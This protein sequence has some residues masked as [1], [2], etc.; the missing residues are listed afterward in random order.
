MNKEKIIEKIKK[1]HALSKS[2]LIDLE[3]I[4]EKKVGK[5][6]KIVKSR[7]WKKRGITDRLDK[8]IKEGFFDQPKSIN[9]IKNRFHKSGLIVKST[10][11]S[12]PLL[13]LIKKDILDRDKKIVNK[14]ELWFYRK[15]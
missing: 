1:I 2:V 13:K 15:K 6:Q 5:E 4:P 8:L 14:K 7:K 12:A 3:Y 10:D 11:L 9:D